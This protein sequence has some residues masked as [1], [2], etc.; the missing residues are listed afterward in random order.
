MAPATPEQIH[1]DVGHAELGVVRWLG[2]PGAPLVVAVHGITANAWSW[3]AV[4]RLLDGEIGLVAVDLRGRGASSGVRG[5]YG[6]RQHADDVATVIEK[7]SAAPAVVAGHSM[8]AFVALACA[9]RHPAAVGPLVLVDGGVSLPVPEGRPPNAVLD[10]MLG[11]SIERL[12]KV[13][14]DRVAYRTMW[15]EHPAFASG[16]TPEI[17]RCVLSDLVPVDGGFRSSVDEL[18]VRTDGAELLTDPEIRTLLDRRAEPAT[19]LRAEFGLNGAPPPLIPLEA[20]DRYPQHDWRNLEGTNH[21]SVLF[22][23]GGADAVATALRHAA[24]IL[25]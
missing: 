7:L 4:A 15:S 1:V 23:G 5:P 6:I 3:A 13:W 14:P 24:A 9:E 8:G 10:A 16:L 18:A 12:R 21:Y 25:A 19:I 20:I 11:P 17:E 2:A 22:D